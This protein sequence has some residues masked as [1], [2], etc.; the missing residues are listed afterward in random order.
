MIDFLILYK[1]EL[2]ASLTAF[3]TIYGFWRSMIP[4]NPLSNR[5]KNLHERRGELIEE[6]VSQKRKEPRLKPGIGFVRQVV[7]RLKL[8]SSNH[9]KDLQNKLA[10]AGYRSRDAMQIFLFLKAALPIIFGGLFAFIAYGVLG[11]KI[12]GSLQLLLCVGGV[13]LGYYAPGLF[14]KNMK[15]RREKEIQKG[16][17]DALDLLVICAQAGLSLDAA[18]GRVADEMALSYPELAD[19]LSLTAVELGFLSKRSDALHH[20]SARVDLSQMR[21][22]VST[23]VQT[24][25]YGTPLSQSLRVLASEYRDE[26]MMKAEEKAARLP[27]ILTLP[28]IVF[29]LPPLFIVLLGPGIL[30]AIDSFRTMN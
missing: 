28:M 8:M 5:L 12:G 4:D 15:Q 25:K 18:L 20:L 24:E 14:V 9:A 3:L 27:A 26:R 29:I 6:Q 7:D 22:L 30:N 10:Q 1:L 13:F 17:P 16:L 19:E 2:G 21:S 23:L 11:G